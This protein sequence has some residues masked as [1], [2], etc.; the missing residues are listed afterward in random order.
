MTQLQW[1]DRYLDRQACR[2]AFWSWRALVFK[3]P[4]EK[5]ERKRKT[6][7]SPYLILVGTKGTDCL[8]CI[9]KT[10]LLWKLTAT[11]MQEIFGRYWELCRRLGYWPLFF[12]VFS[13]PISHD[14]INTFMSKI[15]M[16]EAISSGH[17]RPDDSETPGLDSGWLQISDSR[18]GQALVGRL[19][20][21][22][23]RLPLQSAPLSSKSRHTNGHKHL[24]SSPS[25]RRHDGRLCL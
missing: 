18:P 20:R 3:V 17:T 6:R 12:V 9:W 1:L 11:P 14:L 25:G 2:W 19:N 16:I 10:C 22:R 15:P 5:K 7:T 4:R 23:E 8:T 13:L 21:F 24:F